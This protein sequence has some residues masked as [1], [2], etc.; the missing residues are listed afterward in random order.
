MN[1]DL[2]PRTFAGQFV[3]FFATGINPSSSSSSSLEAEEETKVVGTDSNT[4]S[5]TVSRTVGNQKTEEPQ[6]LKEVSKHSSSSTGTTGTTSVALAPTNS[7]SS[8]TSNPKRS[9]YNYYQ[10]QSTRQVVLPTNSC[11][12]AMTPTR[13]RWNG[14]PTSNN[15]PHASSIASD[16]SKHITVGRKLARFLQRYSW[17]YPSTSSQDTPA[18]LEEGWCYF[19]HVTLPRYVLRSNSNTTTTATGIVVSENTCCHK[20]HKYICGSSH[21]TTLDR[22]EPGDTTQ[23]TRLYPVW[24]TPLSQMGDFGIGIGLYFTTLKVLGVLCLLAGIITLP[25]ILYYSSTNYSTL[26]QSSSLVPNLL[27]LGSAICTD[28]PWVICQDCT[29]QQ[30]LPNGNQ[31]QSIGVGDT[32]DS[33]TSAVTPDIRFASTC[34][35]SSTSS[36]TTTASTDCTI[37]IKKNNCL[38]AQKQQGLINLSAFLFVFVA[39]FF[40]NFYVRRKAIEFD[41]DEQTAQDY[42]ILVRNP[43]SDAYDPEEWRKYFQQTLDDEDVHVTVCTVVV[44]NDLLLQ[45]LHELRDKKRQLHELLLLHTQQQQKQDINQHHHQQQQQNDITYNNYQQDIYE[46]INH[47]NISKVVADIIRNSS[48]IGMVLK[49]IL[50][51]TLGCGWDIPSLYERT[52]V[53]EHRARGLAQLQHP[54]SKVFVTLETEGDQRSILE[55]LSYGKFQIWKNERIRR[56]Q[57]RHTQTSDQNTTNVNNNRW[58]RPSRSQT[59]VVPEEYLFR[60]KYALLVTEPAEP[61]AVR[62]ENLDDTTESQIISVCITTFVCLCAVVLIAYIVKLC[63]DRDP[64]LCAFAIAF[65]NALFPLFA[66]AMTNIESHTDEGQK[67]RS[68]YIKIAVFRWVNTAIVIFIITVRVYSLR[69]NLLVFICFHVCLFYGFSKFI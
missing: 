35:P 48:T 41:E 43:P 25:N 16:D 59:T 5:D 30:F 62:W 14:T 37:F 65:F 13:T 47:N 63:R 54:V 33:T 55:R 44:A 7:S 3:H 69:N 58:K 68:L 51:N 20:L 28:T 38:G 45:T 31:R 29:P 23:T 64:A 24:H 52:L 12:N 9:S 11:T 66:K 26:G 56:Q 18:N 17:Y 42:S 8:N 22:A 50:R 1:R 21:H 36:T 15:P 40:L 2:S 53:L 19:E 39:M 46:N 6:K 49:A 67:Q 57:E 4:A 27:T 32:Y 34:T 10:Y 61:S 60:G